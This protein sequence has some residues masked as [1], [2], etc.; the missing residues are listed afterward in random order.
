[1]FQSLELFDRNLLLTINSTHQVWLDRL[2]WQLSE[3]WHTYLL[4]FLFALFF[5]KKFSLKKAVEIVVGVAIVIACC[6]L[7]ANIVKHSVKRYRPTHN[8]EIKNEIHTVNDYRGGTYGFFSSHAANC[9]GITAFLFLCLKGVSKKIKVLLFIYPAIV[10]YSRV[11]LGVH[12][13]SDVF[14]GMLAGLLFAWLV[15]KIMNRH[16]FKFDEK[17]IPA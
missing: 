9:F 17:N 13:P 3:S 6:D 16:F 11:Y 14:V 5:Y 12:Y 1:M 8:L 2:M 7:S 4:V 15:F 10:A